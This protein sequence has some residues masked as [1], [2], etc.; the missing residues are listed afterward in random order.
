MTAVPILPIAAVAAA[1]LAL[2]VVVAWMLTRR[3]IAGRIDAPEQ[4]MDAAAA[5]LAG[6]RPL[7]AAVGADGAAA[8]VSGAGDRLAVLRAG[9]G[10]VLAREIGWRAVRATAEGMLVETEARAFARVPVAGV[11]ALDMRR[12]AAAAEA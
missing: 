11:D 7:A 5:A 8:L 4:A 9:T 1:G 12:L 2:V 6:F 3:R 10:R